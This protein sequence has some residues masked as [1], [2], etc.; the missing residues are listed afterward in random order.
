MK[1]DVNN[2]FVP[3][4]P[5]IFGIFNNSLI[6]IKFLISTASGFGVLGFG[7]AF[8][9]CFSQMV[10]QKV[11]AKH[12]FF[13]FSILWKIPKFLEIPRNCE[14]PG[15]IWKNLE[16]L[17]I[18]EHLLNELVSIYWLQRPTILAQSLFEH[19]NLYLVMVQFCCLNSHL[20][21][22]GLKL[23]FNSSASS[24]SFMLIWYISSSLLS[25]ALSAETIFYNW[26]INNITFRMGRKFA[27]SL[28]LWL[29]ADKYKDSIL[30][31]Y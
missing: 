21:V 13:N 18:L 30:R 27:R 3:E 20:G 29:F 22:F 19:I 17:V 14:I 12:Y 16:N 15:E 11:P 5:Q 28:L 9:V 1:G 2:S 24:L 6:S 25:L 23:F 10:C 8:F 7:C 4:I 26:H 31:E